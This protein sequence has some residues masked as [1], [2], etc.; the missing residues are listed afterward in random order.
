MRVI[1]K[2]VQHQSN[3]HEGT[4][5]TAKRERNGNQKIAITFLFWLGG[6]RGMQYALKGGR[7]QWVKGE[8][9]NWM[10]SRGRGGKSD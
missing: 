8:R 5:E 6:H 1:F 3:Y 2:Q 7:E 9:K 4:T 10:V